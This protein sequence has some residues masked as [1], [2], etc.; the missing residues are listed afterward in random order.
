MHAGE[1]A[2]LFAKEEMDMMVG[3]LRGPA[4]LENP[5]IEHTTESLQQ[6]FIDRVRDNLHLV[7][8]F[9]PAHPKFAERARRF[10]GI[11][12]GCTIDWFMQWPHEALVE[13]AHKLISG[14]S[15]ASK[16]RLRQ[17]KVRELRKTGSVTPRQTSATSVGSP[18][19]AS[20]QTAILAKGSLARSRHRRSQS[21][22]SGVELKQL[23]PEPSKGA[24][25]H[26][27]QQSNLPLSMSFSDVGPS[28][29]LADDEA[30]DT[31]DQTS[32]DQLFAVSLVVL[33]ACAVCCASVCRWKRGADRV[34]WPSSAGLQ[35][36]R[37][38][39]AGPSRGQCARCRGAPLSGVLSPLP[40]A[41]QRDCQVLLVVH[42]QLQESLR[43]WIRSVCWGEVG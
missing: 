42:R 33:C 11:I 14:V 26:P 35:R 10:P 27:L 28:D 25:V 34:P 22:L 37:R 38:G 8:C 19:T 12:S 6:F 1:I 32:V 20:E 15:Q 16:Q 21:T 9:S 31:A 4:R 29:A 7:L 2:G 18:I 5:L 17:L 24:A 23:D 36:G 41:S 39:A 30:L 40:P 3:D 13:V 43:V